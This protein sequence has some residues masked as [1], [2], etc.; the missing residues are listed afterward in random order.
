MHL[1]ENGRL[2]IPEGVTV[3]FSAGE[4]DGVPIP[5]GEYRAGNTGLSAHL[6]GRGSLQIGSLGFLFIIK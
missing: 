1:V 2:E 3:A 4:L 5:M 6:V